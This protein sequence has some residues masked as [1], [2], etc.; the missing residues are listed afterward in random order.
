M[1]PPQCAPAPP[2]ICISVVL[3]VVSGVLV[4]SLICI[5]AVVVAVVSIVP[6]LSISA[7]LMRTCSYIIPKLNAMT[8]VARNTIT[9]ANFEYQV[10]RFHSMLMWTIVYQTAPETP[11]LLS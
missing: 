2:L 1:K 3:A 6:A 5:L 4:D 11:P 10:T 8:N 7:A 9:A